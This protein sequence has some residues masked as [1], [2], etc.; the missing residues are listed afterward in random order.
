MAVWRRPGLL[1][2]RSPGALSDVM[3][4]L[5]VLARTGGVDCRRP[6]AS[7]PPSSGSTAMPIL[8][9]ARWRSARSMIEWLCTQERWSPEVAIIFD[10]AARNRRATA[11][12]SHDDS[13]QDNST[14][15]TGAVRP[16]IGF[17]G[18]LFFISPR[19]G[20]GSSHV[21]KM[22]PAFSCISCACA[23]GGR[24]GVIHPYFQWARRSRRRH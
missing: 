24:G 13:R 22:L 9:V 17:V 19:T 6:C 10:A 11:G 7:F 1:R 16:H 20:H 12:S 23:F 2:Q 15:H 8:C 3:V 21:F 14:L 5:R 18:S 4:C